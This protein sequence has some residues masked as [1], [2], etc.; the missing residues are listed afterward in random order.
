MLFRSREIPAKAEGAMGM[1]RYRNMRRLL[2]VA[3]MLGLLTGG[4]TFY[5]RTTGA[6]TVE[7]L[8]AED[9]YKAVYAEHMDRLRQDFKL[10]APT[11]T[12]PGVCNIGGTKQGCYDADVKIISS[13]QEML[14][15]LEETQVP[16]RYEPADALLKEALD[17]NIRA[18]ELRNQGIAQNDDA[19]FQEHREVME[20]ALA[21]WAEA[22]AAFPTDNP[23]QP[24]P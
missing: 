4:C 1:R 8:Q 14:E 21:Q 7:D 16:P 18:L 11:A 20:E 17:L 23:P 12:S 10:L 9:R 15:A 24:P 3:I 19:A 13:L 2:V 22:Y 6:E 5:T